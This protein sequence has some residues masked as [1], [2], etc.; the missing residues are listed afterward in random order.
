MFEVIAE[1]NRAR[2]GKIKIGRK[3]IDTPAFLP[4][5]TK[6]CIKTL[7]PEEVKKIGIKA[8]I[9]NA[10]HLYRRAMPLVEKVGIHNFM[11]WNGIIFSDSGGFQSIKRFPAKVTDEGIV[12]KMPDGK[13]ELFTP[14]KCI[15]VQRKI[16]SDFMFCLDDCPAYPYSRKRVK[17][18]VE[19]TIE[20]AQKCQGEN[21]FAILQGGI[22][23]DLRKECIKKISHLE[24]YGFA[25]GGLS[26]G[27]KRGEMLKIVDLTTKM[28]PVEK[29]RHLMG[30]G[31]PE[32]IIDCVK[33]GV[34][35][36]DSAFPTRNARH[37][38][39]FTSSGKI[40]LGKKKVE[41]DEI[42]KECKC[43]TCKNFSLDY[44]NYLFKEKEQL[45]MRLA[46]IHNLYFMQRFME[47]VREKIEEGKI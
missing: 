41:G 47:E 46:T 44:L 30:V 7:T 10:L 29:P 9:V 38:T 21:V 22:Y 8:I 20:W 40:N 2:I 26:I 24:F 37:G 27:E 34:D 1:I 35:I 18:A 16:G 12:F 23:D 31:S 4:V 33:Y 39:I 19:R 3:E 43:Y 15:E 32:D 11:K 5:A 28:L 42:D 36:F 25:I 13:N 6:G 45:A 17:K 14:E